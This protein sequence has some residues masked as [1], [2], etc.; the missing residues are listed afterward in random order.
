MKI[1]NSIYARIFALLI[2]A[3][4]SGLTSA[5]RDRAHTWPQSVDRTAQTVQDE[6]L[7]NLEAEKTLGFL[8]P[9]TT[10]TGTGHPLSAFQT[11]RD[12]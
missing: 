11:G 7:C 2:A 12:Q 3:A 1:M 8:R 5:Q 6:N 4:T 10:P 9:V